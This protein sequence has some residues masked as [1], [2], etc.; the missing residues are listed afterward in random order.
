[1]KEDD[2]DLN[3]VLENQKAA[4]RKIAEKLKSNEAFSPSAKKLLEIVDSV[5][6]DPE[7]LKELREEMLK[8]YGE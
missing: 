3:K 4:F 5:Y 6:N 7:A 8:H 1:M 2:K